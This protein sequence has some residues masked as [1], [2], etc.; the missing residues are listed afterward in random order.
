VM[1]SLD[2]RKDVVVSFM[3]LC[4]NLV[5]EDLCVRVFD[6]LS[7]QAGQLADSMVKAPAEFWRAW[8]LFCPALVEF[9]ESSAV[10]ESVV[11]L[12]RRLGVLM[13]ESDAVL[14]QQVMVDVGLPSLAPLLINSA[15]KR[16]HLCEM[17]Y[18]YTPPTTFSRL[19]VLRA[20]KEAMNN[21]PAYIACLS[22]LVPLELQA[23][24]L[25]EHLFEHYIHFAQMALLNPQPKIRVAGLSILANVTS[26]SQEYSQ[27]IVSLLPLFAELVHDTWW[28]VQ[29]QL[30]LLTSH[31]LA[32]LKGAANGEQDAETE[33]DTIEA[34]LLIVSRLFGVSST[35]KIVLQVGLC[36][37]VRNLQPYPVLL[38]AYVAVLLRQPQSLRSRLLTKAEDGST[39]PPR[40]YVMD[41]SCRL[42]E[43]CCICKLWPALEVARTLAGQAEAAGLAH[44]DPEH[45]EVLTAC[46]PDAEAE[47]NKE[48]LTVF[49]KIKAYVF[50]ALIDPA[51]HY[52][53]TV[54]VRR[55][56]LCQPQS[57]RVGA[58][59][60]SKGTLLQTLRINYSD[61]GHTRVHEGDLLDFLREM[62]DAGRET[63][64]MLQSVVDRFREAH[65][66]EFQRSSLDGLFD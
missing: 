48:W 6:G 56:W 30:I 41:N 22:Y 15:G 21:H 16:E 45:L 64:D 25:E 58:I 37:L 55:F 52:G 61:S 14:T 10:F 43:E 1:K 59:E 39:P 5:P 23:E 32:H 38:P 44:F 42:Y 60:A 50:V 53:A 8:T 31:L 12:F 20:L 33:E 62:R 13:G 46:L 11:Y 9:S 35:S 3:E 66:A 65:N 57:A 27:Q 29:A 7:G 54:V 4:S 26:D 51:L 28:E 36:A 24:L 47:L 40:R 2:P 34:L 49:E 19:G 17:V 63:N 18:T